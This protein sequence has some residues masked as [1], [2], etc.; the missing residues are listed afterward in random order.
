MFLLH[1]T[2]MTVFTF[3]FVQNF[4]KLCLTITVCYWLSEIYFFETFQSRLG[5]IFGSLWFKQSSLLSAGKTMNSWGP[6]GF[7]TSK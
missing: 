3:R 5:R 2:K 6:N 1:D 7:N 4:D